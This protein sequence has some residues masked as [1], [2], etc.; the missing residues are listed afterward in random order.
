MRI[1]VTFI[2]C[3]IAFVA[4]A[5]QRKTENLIVITLDGFR[6]QEVFAGA[7]SALLF[8]TRYSNPDF[9]TTTFWDDSPEERREKLMPFL[10]EV[11]ANQGQL[12]G[13]RAFHNR[14]ICANPY[15]ASYPGYS[16]LFTG[17]VDK[18]LMSN[19]KKENPNGNILEA[20]QARPDF[21]DRV[22][23]FSTWDAVPYILRAKRNHITTNPPHDHSHTT[24]FTRDSITFAQAFDYLKRDHPKVLYISFDATDAFAHGG[25]YDQYL[26]AAHRIDR[27]IAALWTWTRSQEDYREKTS[28]LITTDHG[29]G[30]SSRSSWVRHGTFTPGSGQTWFA[31]MGPDTPP[32]GEIRTETRHY[33]K[34]LAQTMA[35]ILGVDFSPAHRVAPAVAGTVVYPVYTGR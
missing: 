17:F 8:N 12:Y 28:L 21:R 4:A 24:A 29:R 16:E 14:V 25:H 30:R 1:L 3:Q 10:W 9:N 26:Q 7:D 15:W 22:G 19:K 18:S 32:L 6:W 34:Q 35:N 5:Q 27:M 13:N 23:V 2:L 31:L 20:V 11:L 33:Q